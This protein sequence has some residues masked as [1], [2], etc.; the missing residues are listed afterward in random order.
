MDPEH[1]DTFARSLP[2]VRS[3]RGLLA[4]VWGIPL[5]ATTL[6]EANAKKKSCPPCK[7]RKKGKCRKTLP[8]GTPCT[9]G[10]CERGR[11]A[12]TP[13]PFVCPTQR[14]CGPGCCPE[15]QVCGSNGACVDPSCCSG[16]ATCGAQTTAGRLC[17][18]APRQAFCCCDSSPGAGNGYAICCAPGECPT[19]CPTSTGTGG[20]S[21]APNADGIC[22]RGGSAG[23]ICPG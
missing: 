7:K 14:V 10:T 11:C 20:T 5:G 12:A 22:L 16:D 4:T 9:G 3:R 13:P 17:C 15:G 19:N 18:I 6:A 1:F 23:A 21:S 8:D 2:G